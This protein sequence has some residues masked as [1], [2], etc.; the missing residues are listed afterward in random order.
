MAIDKSNSPAWVKA[1]I[2]L[3]VGGFVLLGL[4]V[5]VSAILEGGTNTASSTGS[6]AASVNASD[7]LSAISKQ[8]SA[9]AQ[10]V[11]G[12]IA[13]DPGNADLLVGQA[14]VYLDWANAILAATDAYG[15]ARPTATVS[16]QY[17]ERAFAIRPGDPEQLKDYAAALFYSGDLAR[18]TSVAEG[19][20]AKDPKYAPAYFNLGVFYGASNRLDDAIKAYQKALDL[21]P[22]GPDVDELKTRIQQLEQAKAS[23]GAT[24]TP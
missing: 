10:A 8:Y 18:A 16:V 15:E 1:V 9:K 17:W 6:D 12:Q 14:R 11:D 2:W 7:T 19:I 22:K 23:A 4:G 5:S 20:V 13:E 21:D 24:Q 3:V